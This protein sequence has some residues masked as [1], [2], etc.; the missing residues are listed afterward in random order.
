MSE[1]LEDIIA[2]RRI[3]LENLKSSGMDPY[4]SSTG[5]THTNKEVLE[6]FDS[7]ADQSVTLV[8]RIRSWR[9]MG[10]ILFIHIE[11]G[12]GKVQALFKKDEIGEDQFKFF[13]HNFDIGD[14]IE[15]TGTLFK[16][17]TEEK[18]LQANGYKMLAKSLLPLP[19]EHYGL[20][21]E[22]TKLRKR[23]LD[24]LN[25]PE[26]K[27]LFVKKNKFWSA[28]RNYL[29]NQGFLELEMPALEAVPGGAEAEP[30]IT[31]H[32]ALGRDFYLRI[33]L[34]LPLKKMLVA[35]YEKVFE[36]GRIFRNEGISTEHLQDYTQME[37]Y[38]A[39]GD[40][41]G[42]LQFVQEMYQYVIRE[43]F[44]TLEIPYQGQVINWGGQWL[45]HD[46]FEL[47]KD[48]TGLDLNTI[49]EN[50]LKAYADKNSITY[51]P[52]AGKG[53]IIDLIFKKKIRIL[54]EVARQPSFLINQPVELE[55]LAKRDPLNPKIVQRMQILA[56]GS[57]L[58]KGFG[59]LNDPL[60]QRERFAAQMKLREA[61]DT[62]AQMLDEDYMEAM[63]YGMPPAA[64]FGISER[65]FAVLCDRSIRETVIFP[66]MKEFS[67]E[68]KTGKAKDT[69]IAVAL[70]NKGAHMEAW[71]E[72]NTIAH[73]TA[74]FGARSGKKLLLQDEISTKD[75]EKIKLNIQ[76]AIMIKSGT[77]SEELKTLIDDAKQAN[78]EI[79]EFTREMIETT[80]D[81]K[82]IEKTK[83]KN[84]SEI[85]YLGVLVFGKKSE[86][87]VLT[88]KLELYK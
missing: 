73:L 38:W 45:R 88:K 87:E 35:G 7:L 55:P 77:S 47:F 81:K 27:E 13:S 44:G 32:N 34:E 74:A 61:G 36:I 82:V 83:S 6:N 3:K 23:Y 30:F 9:D 11:D 1:R 62:E 16:T 79:S 58:G 25:N 19:S 26:T 21:D 70:I 85:E 56:C 33:S 78:L 46:Y 71:Q 84:A 80:D 50:E 40:F 48:F 72:M 15:I 53:R 17:K 65:L 18:T 24:I 76:H 28:M 43:T 22:E 86:V 52:T 14:F 67:S 60:D 54:P 59:E 42:L 10:K 31:H 75:R 64:G 37:F 8:G 20:A 69:Y 63:E 57:E 29:V 5:R 2:N 12:S 66:P 4:P 51:E 41:E 49:E 68:V 39:Y